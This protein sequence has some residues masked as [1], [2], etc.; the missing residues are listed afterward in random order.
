MIRLKHLLE[1][2]TR[3]RIECD[4]C[5]WSWKIADGGSDLY[6][7]HRCGH[8]NT[9]ITENTKTPRN[10]RTSLSEITLGSVEPYA[11][12]FVWSDTGAG[13]ETRVTCDGITVLFEM[14][15]QYSREGEEYSFAIA[16]P[17]STGSGFTVTH[18][19]SGVAGQL[20][21]LRV[22]RTALEAILDFCAQ[23]APSAIDVTG[24]DTEAAKDL[25][26]TRIY[27]DLLMGNKMQL[28]AAGY[29][30][31]YRN[32]KLWIVRKHAYDATGVK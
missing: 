8:D 21:Y 4:E 9:P 29:L 30:I 27:R 25:Q 1:L 24:F 18:A 31:F 7:C 23:Y 20:S 14:G 32:G 2:V 26:K 5:G 13:Y 11:I 19:K 16:M 15:S 6:V 28:E 17:G 3:T 10:V 12:Q 22:L